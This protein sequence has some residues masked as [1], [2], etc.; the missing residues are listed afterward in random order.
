MDET[1]RL[2]ATVIARLVATR[3]VSARQI[4]ADALTRLAAVN[5][6]IN[7]VVVEHPEE[8]LAEAA[9]I[10]R[11]IAAGEAPGPLAGV[12]VTI[13]EITDQKGH[14]TT[15]GLTLQK[16]LIAPQDSTVVANLRK[17]GCVVLGRTNTP[18]FSMRWFTRN[19]LRGA[20]KNPHDPAITPGGSSGGAAA[21]VAAGIGALAQGTD[22]AGSV[23]FP[24]YVCNLQGLRPSLG[25]VA[26]A[27][28]TGLERGIG[29]QL[30]SVAGPLARSLDDLWAMHF[31]LS[32]P[33][34]RDPWWTPM[35]HH[36]PA[37]PKRVAFCPAPEGLMVAP[38]VRLALEGAARLLE[39][40]G[41]VVEEAT[42]PSLREGVSINIG[43]WMADFRRLGEERFAA[44]G[45][46]DAL[47]VARHL[48]A[49]ALDYPSLEEALVR[50]GSLVRA[51]GAFLEDWPLVLMPISAEPPFP[52]HLD[53]ESQAGW[54]RVF[55][56]Q[57]TQMGLPPVGLPGLTVATGRAGAP[58]GVQLVAERFREDLLF[59]AGRII[60]AAHPPIAPVDPFAKAGT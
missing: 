40:A 45:D 59:E 43:L 44:E 5:P 50:R 19:Q 31:A 11:R 54:D 27:N 58:M 18:A 24:A 12:P 33:D 15:N 60:E 23:R 22:I 39:A 37:V 36:G 42:P 3:Q 29:P 2:P 25:R 51:W 26:Q 46:P 35:A 48:M 34:R 1:W 6:A 55:E 53:V 49:S 21:A 28:P 38:E 32:A 13:K 14:A 16:D 8:T 47:A 9:E 30:M 57:L 10:D 41:Y 20:T 4:A 56:A 7:A 17:A 52:D